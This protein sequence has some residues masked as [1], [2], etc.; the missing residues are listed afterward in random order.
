MNETPPSRN[1][2]INAVPAVYIKSS[3]T[4]VGAA[5]NEHE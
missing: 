2:S 5:T 1:A 4:K 3:S